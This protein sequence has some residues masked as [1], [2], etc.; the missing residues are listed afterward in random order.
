MSEALPASCDLLVIGSGAGGLAAAVTAAA[1][2]LDVVV[3]EKEDHFGGT[4]AWSGGWM[5]LP[6]NPLALAAGIDEDEATIRTY[7]RHELGDDYDEA[8]VTTLLEQGPRMVSFFQRETAVDFVDGN[9]IPDFHGKTPGASTGGRSLCA[10]PFDGRELGPRLKDLR[11]PLD[12]VAPFGM[13][14]GSG[15]DL[16][17]FLNATRKLPSFLHVLHRLARHFADRAR[18]GR[19]LHLVNGNALA[20]RLLKSADD[21]GVTLRTSTAAVEMLREG[22]QIAGAVVETDGRRQRIRAGRGVVLA[23]GGFPHDVE[24]RAELFPHAPTGKEHW[25][26]A[27]CANTGDGIRLGEAAGGHVQAGLPNAGAWAPV[28]LVP[29]PDGSIG[30]FPHLVER[31]KPGAIIVRRNGLRFCNEADSYHDVMQA[32]FAATP[33]GEPAEA[34]LVCDDAFLRRYGLGRARPRP[35]PIRPWLRSGYLRRGDTAEALAADCGIDVAGFSGTL[36]QYNRDAAQGRDPAFGRGETPYNRVQGDPEHRPNPCVAPIGPGPF[37]AVKIVP[38]SLGTF[39]GLKT[40]AFA[41]VLDRNGAP[42]PGLY[43]VGNDMSSMMAGRYP[44][45]GITLGPAMTFGYVAAHHASGVPL[46]NNRS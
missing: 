16:R 40:D 29:K 39:A 30:R 24:R 38:G 12:E 23:T 9:L 36:A 8:F 1:L 21:L 10:K 13:N 44:A 19:G 27:P 35:F 14:I 4:T 34:W 5:W 43:A 31:A 45:G 42:I 41:R 11:P 18:H 7:L 32:L 37:Y 20:A 46:A 22:D 28:S 25:S 17:H 3:V 15:A 26:A 6:R 2:G 33:P